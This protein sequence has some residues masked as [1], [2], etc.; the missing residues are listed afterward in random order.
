MNAAASGYS[1]S[2]D[3]QEIPIGFDFLPNY[4]AALHPASLKLRAWL[5]LGF[6]ETAKGLVHR[7]FDKTN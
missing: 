7:V 5:Q 2:I 4:F 6:V 3:E 1:Y